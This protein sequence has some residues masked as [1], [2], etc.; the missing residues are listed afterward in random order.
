MNKY[1]IKIDILPPSE[2]RDPAKIQY[3]CN[4]NADINDLTIK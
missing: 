4:T 2:T 1:K 3:A